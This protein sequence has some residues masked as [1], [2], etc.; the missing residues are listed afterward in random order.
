MA[1]I[2]QAAAQDL[3]ERAAAVG[4]TAEQIAE[5]V[6]LRVDSLEVMS[7]RDEAIVERMITEREVA[8]QTQQPRRRPTG[9][10]LATD[11]QVSYIGDLL[12]HRS[13]TGDGDGYMSVR[14]LVD[15]TGRPDRAA[16]SR[17]TRA[18]ASAVIDSLSGSY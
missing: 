14:G 6:R 15:E 18:Q 5:A 3:I 2:G 12:R 8:R 1:A 4:Y 16:I 7:G 11:R 17:M 13:R 9:T 10:A